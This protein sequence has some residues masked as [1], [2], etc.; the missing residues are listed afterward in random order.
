MATS[1]YTVAFQGME[2]KE[3]EVQCTLS[4]GMPAF[5]LVGLPDKA[6]AESKERVRAAISAL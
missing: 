2:A 5:T 1:A 6:V 4:P 3:V